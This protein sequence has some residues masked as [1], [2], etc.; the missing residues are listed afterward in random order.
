MKNLK[1][2]FAIVFSAV[3]SLCFT[4]GLAAYF[5]MH[6]LLV[7]AEVAMH[8][9]AGEFI[10]DGLR[11]YLG[12]LE[13]SSPVTLYLFAVPAL[14]SRL[15]FIHPIAIFNELTVLV[16]LLVSLLLISAAVDVKNSF[17]LR[18]YGFYLPVLLFTM[19]VS[20]I[21]YLNEFGQL[22]MFYVILVLPYLAERF[23]TASACSTPLRFSATFWRKCVTGALA[24]VA[25]LLDPVLALAFVAIEFICLSA[26]GNVTL[27]RLKTRYCSV[28]LVACLISILST[29]A[30]LYLL[31]P[32]VVHEYLGPI[33]QFN[34]FS[35][36]FFNDA[37]NYVDKS[38]DRRDL[39]YAFVFFVVLALPMAAKCLL[40]RL[41]STV[42]I[43]GFI[44][45]ICT[46]TLFTH[47]SFTMVAASAM[48]CA[49]AMSRYL[50]RYK[51][52]FSNRFKM[53]SSIFRL[54]SFSG[55]IT[56]IVCGLAPTLTFMAISYICAH[57][58]PAEKIF[59]LKKIGY[60]GFGLKSDL[61]FFSGSIERNSDAKDTVWIYSEQ[62]SPG[63]PVLTQ[64]H[65][66]PGRLVWG[67]PFR[68]MRELHDRNT[69][70]LSKL[71]LFEANLHARLRAELEGS[72]PPELVLIED[73]ETQEY[74]KTAKIWPALEQNYVVL[75]ACTPLNE[76]EI[77][78]HAPY[79]YLGY[80]VGFST[81]RLNNVLH[82]STE[83]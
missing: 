7:P 62:V 6:Q 40:T 47:Q 13:V 64:L 3:L 22:G 16:L 14:L 41:L 77:T 30:G 24:A 35:Y 68:V 73:G 17:R 23:L 21:Y 28:E 61:G 44:F 67:F 58:L 36:Q 66:R 45:F 2:D 8:I 53:L 9:S 50:F 20:I 60:Y 81:F 83:N 18:R 15:L 80:R 54:P 29:V 37:L 1:L 25:T 55:R 12:F 79:E 51:S 11:P 56:V 4:A 75:E 70:D 49:L 43:A 78:S 33:S 27:S 31:A 71:L 46:G 48:A 34:F 10:V 39:M 5:A 74:F 52:R 63:F 65:R 69:D 57:N 32:Q 42:A 19:A 72:H 59:D 76:A 26:L 38:P 82:Q